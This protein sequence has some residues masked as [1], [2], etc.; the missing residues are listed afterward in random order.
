MKSNQVILQWFAIIVVFAA[1]RIPS[2]AIYRSL[3]TSMIMIMFAITKA[4]MSK[5]IS[6]TKKPSRLNQF[7][8]LVW[9]ICLAGTIFTAITINLSFLV[10]GIVCYR[11]DFNRLPLSMHKYPLFGSIITL[12]YLVIT[13][14][15]MLKKCFKQHLQT[16]VRFIIIS[17]T[18]TLFCFVYLFTLT[19]VVIGGDTGNDDVAIF[20]ITF[21]ML[22]LCLVIVSAKAAF[23][24]SKLNDIW[25]LEKMTSKELCGIP[26][27]LF[28]IVFL[29][30]LGFSL[31]MV[32]YSLHVFPTYY[33]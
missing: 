5:Q 28:A 30:F 20:V 13:H 27:L 12:T 16:K 21:F 26:N 6:H 23:S 3:A 11:K 9:I 22:N 10:W 2:P 7:K 17:I 18:H 1:R 31:I 33:A 24:V 32:L 4:L 25:S 8:Q 19:D 29:T 15:L 14:I